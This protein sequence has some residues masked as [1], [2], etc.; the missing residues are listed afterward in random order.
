MIFNKS[1]NKQTGRRLHRVKR[2][3]ISFIMCIVLAAVYTLPVFAEAVW[4]EECYVASEGACMMDADSGVILFDK[5]KNTSYYPASITKV[6]TALVVLENCEN[7]SETVTFSYDAVHIEEEN[8]TIIGASEGDRL[9]VLDCLYCLLF[10]SANEVANALAEHTGAKHAE[11]KEQGESDRDVFVKLMNAK[12]AEL[13]CTGTHFNN[14]SGLTDEQHYTTPEDMCRIM[15]AAIRN[16]TFLDIESHTYWK[17][18]PIRRYSDPE[19]PWNTVYPKHLMLKKNSYQYYAGCIAGKTGYT[20]NAGNT[21]VT[22]CR[23]NGM[24]LVVCVM[25]AHA[26][27]YNDTRRLFD[28]GFDNFQS[29]KISDYDTT[30]SSVEKD[31]SIGGLP[32]LD[33]VTLG[34]SS[35]A[36][37]TLP[38]DATFSEV[39][40]RLEKL[41][42]GRAELVYSY[43][44]R[45]VG[46]A[47]LETLPIGNLS[48]VRDMQEDEFLAETE[49]GNAPD[50]L[51]GEAEETAGAE[52]AAAGQTAELQPAGSDNDK[53][54]ASDKNGEPAYSGGSGDSNAAN[55]ASADGGGTGNVSAAAG[56]SDKD[57][58]GGDAS[59]T[60]AEPETIGKSGMKTIVRRILIIAGIIAVI[61]GA[62]IF[63]AWRSE[64]KSMRESARRRQQRLKNTR[65]FTGEQSIT[66]DLMLQQRRDKNKKRK[67]R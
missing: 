31:L 46:T 20:I 43:G 7:L 55:A 8:S 22:A 13:G 58:D 67:R 32:L 47:V 39:T 3:L 56:A 59:E 45:E 52:A 42:D 1:S 5:N 61:A 30:Y 34:I 12:A 38:G 49:R 62:V 63:I 51:G 18:A 37:I 40:K 25:N 35:D 41:E 19:D 36:R 66:M 50:I 53:D 10:Q 28:F 44:S 17:H 24:T 65:D 14:P 48:S 29:V 6:M 16:D 64:V 2:G 23:K 4:P 9:S 57:T 54:G 27:H 15:R 60:A 33:S 21:L 11:L 26:N